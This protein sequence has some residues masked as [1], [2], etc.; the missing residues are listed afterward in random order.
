MSSNPGS[1]PRPSFNRMNPR[2]VNDFASKLISKKKLPQS[3][4]DQVMVN[5]NKAYREV[6]LEQPQRRRNQ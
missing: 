6:V 5:M 2:I 4:V 1:S 3:T